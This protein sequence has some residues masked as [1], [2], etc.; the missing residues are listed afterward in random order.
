MIRS[1]APAGG[2]SA[3]VRPLHW[4][5]HRTPC[6]IVPRR[7]SLAYRLLTA[8]VTSWC[9]RDTPSPESFPAADLALFL[10]EPGR[11]TRE[12][13]RAAAALPLVAA[14]ITE[15]RVDQTSAITLIARRV[16]LAGDVLRQTGNR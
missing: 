1:H 12:S 6:V 11:A 9:L 8:L 3:P 15:L 2:S 13:P 14:A 7:P 4:D 5:D 16:K 10:C